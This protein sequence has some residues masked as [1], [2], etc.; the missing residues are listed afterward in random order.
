MP[1][2]WGKSSRYQRSA[3]LQPSATES[4]PLSNQG[5]GTVEQAPVSPTD[6]PGGASENGTDMENSTSAPMH[7]CMQECYSSEQFPSRYPPQ[8]SIDSLISDEKALHPSLLLSVWFE[9]YHRQLFCNNTITREEEIYCEDSSPGYVADA[10]IKVNALKDELI[11]RNTTET[12]HE[13]R[14]T[15]CETCY[16]RYLVQ[17]KCRNGMYKV[18][19]SMKYLKYNS[20]QQKWVLYIN[21]DVTV[22]CL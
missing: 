18:K 20:E 14:V 7:N 6:A 10:K 5:A 13:Y 16:P 19:K 8:A 3:R 17:V 4:T 9:N 2:S 11:V 12:L 21:D 22:A 15:Y 1:L